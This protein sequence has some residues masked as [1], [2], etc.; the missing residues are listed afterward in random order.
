MCLNIIGAKLR[1]LIIQKM[2][3]INKILC[4]N[5]GGIKVNMRGLIPIAVG[6]IFL[7]YSVIYKNKIDIKGIDK[8]IIVNKEKLL[9]LQLYCSIFN[10]VCMIIVGIIIFI[11]NV[12]NIYGAAYGLIFI[13]INNYLAIPIGRSQKYIKYK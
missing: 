10:S 1:R 4:N 5:K 6:I 2:R 13:F 11:Y 8:F 3:H 12:P 9:T 7:I